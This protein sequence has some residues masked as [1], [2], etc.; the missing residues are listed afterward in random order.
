MLL[1][2]FHWFLAIALQ[3]NHIFLHYYICKLK[4]HTTTESF[5]PWESSFC[6]QSWLSDALPFLHLDTQLRMQLHL[7]HVQIVQLSVHFTYAIE[8]MALF[9]KLCSQSQNTQTWVPKFRH[10]SQYFKP[11]NYGTNNIFQKW[12]VCTPSIS[13]SGNHKYLALLKIASFI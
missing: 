13:F 6:Q 4:S 1:L 7:L 11:L 5:Y 9:L 2:A 8:Q 3:Q 12:G 10:L